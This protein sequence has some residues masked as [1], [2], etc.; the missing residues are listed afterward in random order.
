[1]LLGQSWVPNPK[2]IHSVQIRSFFWSVFS[3]IRTEY[4]KIV[5]LR[6]QSECGKI[7]TRKSS[8]FGPFPR[9]EMHSGTEIWK[10]QIL[11]TSEAFSEL[12]EFSRNFLMITAIVGFY[13]FLKWD[14]NL[15]CM[16]GHFS[17]LCIERWVQELQY[18]Y[19]K[20]N[21]TTSICRHTFLLLHNKDFCYYL[22]IL[23]ML[24]FK[25]ANSI[26]KTQ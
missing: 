19:K 26:K 6:I 5:S 17:I 21:V 14:L 9:N 1:M 8:V 4:G 18:N 23:R 20:I 25:I 10:F 7:R 22:I 11:N 15:P 24:I 16:F 13:N 3:R 2:Q 12:I